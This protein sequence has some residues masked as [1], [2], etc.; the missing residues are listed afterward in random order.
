MQD[1]EGLRRG[2]GCQQTGQQEQDPA[3][4]GRYD[5]TGNRT[6]GAR[7]RRQS[8]GVVLINHNGAFSVEIHFQW[9]S[10]I[11]HR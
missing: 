7:T 1:R 3:S 5:A 10:H 4:R 6:T 11:A 8:L 2:A 9:V